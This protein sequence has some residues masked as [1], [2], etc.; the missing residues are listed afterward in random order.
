MPPTSENPLGL[1]GGEGVE[2]AADRLRQNGDD[3]ATNLSAPFT[4]RRDDCEVPIADAL[5]VRF[6]GSKQ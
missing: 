4:D 6:L 1:A 2:V 5:L 3:D